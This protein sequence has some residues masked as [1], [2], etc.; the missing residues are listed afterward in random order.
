MA[1]KVKCAI[2]GKEKDVDDKRNIFWCAKDQ[3]WVCRDCRTWDEKCPRC[4]EKLK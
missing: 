4:K 1:Q 3:M 2:C